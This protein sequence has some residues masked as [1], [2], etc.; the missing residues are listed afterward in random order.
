MQRRRS[1]PRAHRADR[2]RAALGAVRGL[3][4]AGEELKLL[5]A[6]RVLAL[7]R[8]GKI[9]EMGERA[10][11]RLHVAPVHADPAQLG[12]PALGE[13]DERLA[14]NGE[15]READCAAVRVP[16]SLNLLRKLNEA[17]HAA[18]LAVSLLAPPRSRARRGILGI[19][20][21]FAPSR[22]VENLI[23]NSHSVF[24]ENA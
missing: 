7:E 23:G 1:R 2:G 20:G 12:V 24:K 14:E 10:I 8:Q 19:H 6:A 13:V 18:S 21:L 22:A 17:A 15:Q 16:I 5:E 9:K 3:N 4:R 11:Q